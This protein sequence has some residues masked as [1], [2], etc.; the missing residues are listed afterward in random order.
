M[1]KP[2]YNNGYKYCTICTA[3]YGTDW[4]GLRCPCCNTK[5]RTKARYNNRK[6]VPVVVS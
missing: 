6:K 3:W 5:L 4:Q 2:R 1:R